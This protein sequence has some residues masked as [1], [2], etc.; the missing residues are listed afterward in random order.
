MVP[1]FGQGNV[2][3]YDASS[4]FKRACAI[5]LGQDHHGQNKGMTALCLLQWE[6]LRTPVAKGVQAL[7]EEMN[8]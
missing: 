4:G 7:W 3:G 1:C 8:D 2:N 5:W 6:A